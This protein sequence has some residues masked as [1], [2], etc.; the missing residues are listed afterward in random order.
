MKY[1]FL[2]ILTLIIFSCA[3]SKK[4]P[5]AG[6]LIGD[7]L[8]KNIN[9]VDVENGVIVSGQDVLITAKR[10][11]YIGNHNRRSLAAKQMIDGSG[12][13]LIPGVWDMHV[14]TLEE[15]WYKWQFPLFIANGIIGFREMW[16]DRN[17]IDSVRRE[18]QKETMPF[19]SFHSIR[20][21]P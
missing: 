11:S 8:I 19:F 2:L 13:Y 7:I 5:S 18:I 21:H 15:D 4:I 3:T 10:I 1:S 17:L 6:K 9:I 20:T 14:H 16:G 12:K